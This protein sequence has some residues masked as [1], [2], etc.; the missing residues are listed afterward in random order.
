MYAIMSSI[1]YT[2]NNTFF[3]HYSSERNNQTNKLLSK[4]KFVLKKN[5]I[6]LQIIFVLSIGHRAVTF[7]HP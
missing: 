1:N 7:I 4:C 5:K 6:F 3:K 2:Q